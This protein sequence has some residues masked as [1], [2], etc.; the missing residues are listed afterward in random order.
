M[1]PPAKLPKTNSPS[2]DHIESNNTEVSPKKMNV[3]KIS[4]ADQ[5][6]LPNLTTTASLVQKYRAK[7]SPPPL[8]FLS[9][10]TVLD[11]VIPEPKVN[12]TDHHPRWIEQVENSVV[13]E[14]QQPSPDNVAN[15]THVEEEI[16][17]KEELIAQYQPESG[18][19]AEAKRREDTLETEY[20]PDDIDLNEILHI[21]PKSKKLKRLKRNSLNE[22]KKEKK[23]SP[24]Q[25]AINNI[26]A[27]KRKEVVIEEYDEQEEELPNLNAIPESVKQNG[28]SP[29]I[30]IANSKPK[31]P[32]KTIYKSSSSNNINNTNINNTNGEKDMEYID[33]RQLYDPEENVPIKR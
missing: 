11:R 13:N 32:L 8:I 3:Q 27:G 14:H 26:K 12:G 2:R 19:I 7:S 15:G 33:D 31:E 28:S 16:N 21:K 6:D 18:Q 5:S 1:S 20:E 24:I 10:D 29:K 9:P 25:K 17:R 23:M 4:D 30:Q 22:A